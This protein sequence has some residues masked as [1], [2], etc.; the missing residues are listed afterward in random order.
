MNFLK[1]YV[2]IVCVF[3]VFFAGDI[4]EARRW[5]FRKLR[6]ALKKLKPLARAALKHIATKFLKEKL[7]PAASRA[8]RTKK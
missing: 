4:V 1:V 3:L 5:K 6:K 2:L 8:I 7:G